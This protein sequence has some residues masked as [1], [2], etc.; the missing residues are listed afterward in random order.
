[1]RPT[2]YQSDKVLDNVPTP[3]T[4]T[5]IVAPTFKGR[6]HGPVPHEIISPGSRGT[7]R[8]IRLTNS[9]GL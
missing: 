5:S 8:E 3:S 9:S 4:E 1:M 2:S 7:S 6:V